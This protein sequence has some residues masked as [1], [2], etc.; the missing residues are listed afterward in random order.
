MSGGYSIDLSGKTAVVTGASSGIGA[1]IACRMADAGAATVAVGRD[2]ERL[3]E[4]C[5]STDGVTHELVLDITEERAP[6][7]IVET[8]LE[9]FGGLDV[10]VHAAGIFVVA[11]FSEHTD[12]DIDRQW[13][14]NVRAPFRITRAALPHLKRG[15]SVIFISSI[16][17]AAGGDGCSAYCATKGAVE[18]LGNAL[19]VELAHTGVRFN[20]IAPG[21]ILSPMNERLR[22]DAEFYEFHREFAPAKRW[23]TVDDVAPAAVFLASDDADFF[24][25]SRIA[26]DG[27]WIAR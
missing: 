4:A 19:A 8:A 26:I 25:G 15:S 24:H 23:G 2:A 11:P 18:Q 27:G 9:R 7:L 16:M 5:Q 17:G 21:A 6:E 22:E 1:A 14:V 12:A 20:C 13:E 3:A 10:I